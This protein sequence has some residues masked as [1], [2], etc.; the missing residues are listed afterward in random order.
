MIIDGRTL[1]K[2]ILASA[3]TRAQALGRPPLVV[4]LVASDT[5]ATR[6]YL[7]MKAKRAVDAGCI[8]ETRALG[9]PFDDADA[10]IVQLPVPEGINQKEAC[11]TITVEK[12][13][14]VLS[15]ATR[16][17]FERG[18]A[19]VL[20]PPV[21]GA[22]AE[23]FKTY[24]V[25]PRGKKAVVIG[26]GWLVGSPCAVWL[27]QQGAEVSVLTSK[28]DDLSAPLRGA[29]IVVSGAG[30]QHLI[31]PDMLKQGVVLI[32]AGTSESDGTLAGDAD[33]ACV[34]KC[35]LFTPVPGGV[36]PLAVACLFENAVALT[37][38]AMNI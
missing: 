37:E 7:A 1:A 26:N 28:S 24:A 11:D 21:V 35:S 30:S 4:A 32:D 22:V 14:D 36:G 20:L 33:P 3:K 29:D 27:T 31:K 15:S 6:S 17:K 18:D 19:D 2:D 8:L 34:V 16:G 23:I 5:P 10:V 12:D 9:A 25:E 13:A 38:K